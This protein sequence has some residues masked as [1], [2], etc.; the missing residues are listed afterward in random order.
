MCFLGMTFFISDGI[1]ITKG[2]GGIV[3]RYTENEIAETEEDQTDEY[4]GETAE[5]PIVRGNGMLLIIIQLIVSA[6]IVIA[7][8]V[9]KLIGGEV[10][11][12]AAA[13]FYDNY[14]NS[15][16]TNTADG[17]IPYTDNIKLKETSKPAPDIIIS[18]PASIAQ[19]T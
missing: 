5:K 16:F 7:A 6:V 3:M 11:G 9:I 13:W 10:H 2:K 1:Y 19:C 15:V 17:I 12:Q 8:L 4:S 18:A 14:N